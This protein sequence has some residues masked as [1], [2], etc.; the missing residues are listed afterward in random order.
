MFEFPTEKRLFNNLFLFFSPIS[1]YQIG[2]YSLVSLMQLQYG[3]ESC[4]SFKT[5]ANQAALLLDN[6][7]ASRTIVPEETPSTWR[8]CQRAL[9]PACHMSL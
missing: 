5:Q 6:P 7:E 3:L 4:A 1:W 2:S 8:P 9:H